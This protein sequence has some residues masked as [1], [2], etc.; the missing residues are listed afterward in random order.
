MPCIVLVSRTLAVLSCWPLVLLRRTS[1]CV[2]RP[3]ARQLLAASSR[4]RCCVRG[5]A[6]AAAWGART[7]HRR[8]RQC[9]TTGL[10]GTTVVATT[11]SD[12]Y[13][14]LVSDTHCSPC[15][16]S[17]LS[18]QPLERRLPSLWKPLHTRSAALKH[19]R[20]FLPARALQK[21]SDCRGLITGLP[22]DV[23]RR[24]F[25][26]PSHEPKPRGLICAIPLR[27]NLYG[28]H[29]PQHRRQKAGE[30][31]GVLKR[32]ELVFGTLSHSATP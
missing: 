7:V 5:T 30:P 17:S 29:T 20:P 31:S 22:L 23:F 6:A 27:S 15:K 21:T 3:C 19:T 16:T 14:L 9:P 12:L 1:L 26:R 18:P 4:C 11:G 13:H 8:L 32:T 28:T 10:G 25:T 2:R 24:P